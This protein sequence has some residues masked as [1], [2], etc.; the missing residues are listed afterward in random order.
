MLAVCIIAAVS[1]GRKAL[2][3][4]QVLADIRAVTL[5]SNNDLDYQGRDPVSLRDVSSLTG[6][7]KSQLK[8][9]MD[10][11]GL[12]PVDYIVQTSA[13]H[14][15]TIVGEVH[16]KKEYLDLLNAAIP[17]LY[18]EAGVRCIAMEVC[19]ARDNERLH[20]LVTDPQFDRELALE[21]ARHMN[22][23]MWGRKEY[24]DVFET[25]WRVNQTIPEGKT[26]LRV[27]GLS[28][29][30]DMSSV[31][32]VAGACD[33]KVTP[34]LWE[35][36]RILRVLDDIVVEF[37]RDELMARVV[38]RE[39][40][41][42]N[43]IAVVW[44]GLNHAFTD[45]KSPRIREGRVVGTWGR[46]GWILHQRNVGRVFEIALH[47]DFFLPG[48]GG[49]LESLASEED[50][51]PVGFSLVDSPFADL[52][53][54]RVEEYAVQ[55]GLCFADKAPGYIY[56]KPKRE[57]RECTWLRG[58]V[59]RDMFVRNRPFYRAWARVIG[60]DV[61]NAREADLALEAAMTGH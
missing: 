13:A 58:Y 30:V 60:R 2:W 11:E 6:S 40:I 49:F 22:W 37:K 31:M 44:V 41:E 51:H 34:P 43:A 20:R 23:G 27:I 61:T 33:G 17:R 10:T 24:W 36:L 53:D 47:D 59:S 35:R 5:P 15:V 4:R 21:I 25:V 18:H 38:E 26:P 50:M 16:G 19:L 3:A 14:Q 12:E 1:A 45:Y 9:W 7:E 32:L 29:P 52:R 46:M 39:V 54:G 56:V 8:D 42:K 55:P 48:I 57:L 28:P